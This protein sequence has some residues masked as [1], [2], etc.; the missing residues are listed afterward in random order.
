MF[1]KPV[2]ATVVRAMLLAGLCARSSYSHS[3]DD[4]GQCTSR[5]LR[6]VPFQHHHEQSEILCVSLVLCI[7]IY[8]VCICIHVCSRLWGQGKCNK[9]VKD[10]VGGL[11]ADEV[12]M[13]TR[14]KAIELSSKKLS[15]YADYMLGSSIFLR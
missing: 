13:Y 8:V 4:F 6:K 3:G 11:P 15:D 7:C 1:D 14:S 12:P 5:H 2:H 10:G 9:H